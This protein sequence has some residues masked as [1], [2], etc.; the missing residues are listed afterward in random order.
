MFD[1]AIIGSGLAGATLGTILAKHGRSVLLLEAG[2]H[3]RFAIG[4]SV[5]PEFGARA[6][7]LAA[8]FEVPE[9]GYLSNF[10]HL[11][12]HVSGSSGV[13]R[14]FTFMTH[15]DGVEHRTGD[16]CQFQ[17]MTYPLGPDSHLYRPEVDAWLTALAVRY[18]VTYRDR[19]PVLDLSV[20]HDG[21]TLELGDEVVR[22]RFLVDGTGFRSI[23]AE[24]E[25]LRVPPS[26]ATDSRTL[27]THM[28]GVRRIAEIRNGDVSGTVPSPP[29]Q[30][31]LHHLFDGGWFWVIPFDNHTTAVNPIC[32]VGLT[33][34]R[35][36]Y[37]DNDLPA[38]DEFAEFVARF[39]TIAR[40]FQ[41]A[42]PVREWIKT[43]RVQYASRRLAGARWCLLP[44]AAGFVDAL[45]SG[46]NT[47]TLAG[48]Q[49]IARVLLLAFESGNFE[50]ENFAE[51]EQGSQES[52]ELLDRMVHGAF[53]CMKSPELFNAWFRVWAVGNF[54]ASAA[55]IRARLKFLSTKNRAFLEHTHGFPFRRVLGLQQPRLRALLDSVYD[56]VLKHDRGEC[57]EPT[58]L[59]AMYELFAAQD[60]IPP[61]F[62]VADRDRHYLAS[63]TALPLV[64]IIMWGKRNAPAEMR[65]DYYDVGPVFFW[66]LTKSLTREGWRNFSQFARVV[67]NAHFTRGRA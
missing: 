8:L 6:S 59:A 27:F 35:R 5:V 29:D 67:M 43:G 38:G 10:Q 65:D 11:R 64:S 45:F 28:V 40:Q 31:T 7:L 2:S 15:R 1:V 47:L 16:T 54:H 58:T 41:T 32:S 57:D 14:N 22:A 51:Y 13:K 34:D 53:L 49:E 37:P 21:V 24:K 3:P 17:T 30:G 44:H 48:I 36:K 60:W 9:L 61:Q 12:H 46:G 33:L 66:E 20:E 26:M 23:L 63:F 56:L 55:V 52:Q 18:G 25:G 62:H 39:P 42:R 4:E 50:E 19:S